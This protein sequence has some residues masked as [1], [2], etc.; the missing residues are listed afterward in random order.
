MFQSAGKAIASTDWLDKRLNRYFDVIE[1][2]RVMTGYPTQNV[3]SIHWSRG[4]A[5]HRI[6][7][8]EMPARDRQTGAAIRMLSDL[9]RAVI[10][11]NYAR[12]LD[13]AGASRTIG[14]KAQAMGV[15][16]ETF[17]TRLRAARKRL[18]ELLSDCLVR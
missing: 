17:K 9:Q 14:M 5:G 7:M 18:R 6:L 10:V 11:E 3:L 13:D 4:Q 15:P 16:R 8:V 1:N 2:Q 12:H